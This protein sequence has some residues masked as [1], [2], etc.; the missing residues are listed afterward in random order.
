M[1]FLELISQESTPCNFFSSIFQ[2]LKK[3]KPI[4]ETKQTGAKIKPKA[5]HEVLRTSQ[6]LANLD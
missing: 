1:L 2:K 5:E 4:L 3:G 6:R